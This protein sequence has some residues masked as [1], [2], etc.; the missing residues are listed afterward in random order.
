MPV[1]RWGTSWTSISMPTPPRAP[2]LA[3]GAREARRSHVL[4]A[5]ERVGLRSLEAGFEQELSMNGSPTCAAGRFSCSFSSDSAD[6]IV[7]P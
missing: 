2:H 4:D 5:D 7:A 6:A 3:C 1:S